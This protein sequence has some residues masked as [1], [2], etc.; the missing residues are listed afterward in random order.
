MAAVRPFAKL[1]IRLRLAGTSAL[2]TLFILCVFAVAIGTLT[3]RRI[4]SDFYHQ[5]SADATEVG[6]RLQA[7]YDP[8]SRGVA[9][10]PKLDLFG[11]PEH[12]LMRVVLADGTVV[13]QTGKAPNFGAPLSSSI[14]IEGYR[15][16]TRQLRSNIGDIFL[17][18]ARPVS[19][20]GSTIA[21][22]QLFLIV[23]VL[24][25]TGLALAAGTMIAARAMAPIAELTAAARE[26]ERTRDP[27]RSV[28]PSQSEDEV[29][30]LGRTLEN[31]LQ[32]LTDARAETET[33]L[34]RQRAFVADASHELRTPLTSVLANLELL[35]ESL[36]GEERDA[37]RSALRSSQRMRRLVEDLLLL[38]RADLGS[39]RARAHAQLDLADVVIEAAGEL[40]PA[41]GAHVLTLD[42]EPT[43]IVG[44]RDDLHR[45]AIN[46]I[47]NALRHTP[48][49]THI[50]V[51]THTDA[52]GCACLVV[53]DGGPGIPDELR[54]R[55]FERFVRG[56]GDRGGSFGLGLAIVQAVSAAHDGSVSV[57][58][59][60]SGGARFVV[61]P[62]PQE[63]PNE[64]AGTPAMPVP[65]GRLEGAREE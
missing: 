16:E 44:A 36:R 25:G 41:A 34:E 45:V 61:S 47:E 21:R 6:S 55:L 15:V 43:P 1:P 30:E 56:G 52:R 35:E 22:L 46:L 4:R 28:P 14:N 2:L 5:V 19:D 39:T 7:N 18:Y 23:G 10:T 33:A 17:Q 42:A 11:A 8:A 12:T 31:M 49:G 48:P 24:A 13:A 54:P 9:V 27:S 57:E 51:A 58:R 60:A 63:R 32:A 38:A 40:E 65:S 29:A 59:S 50:R 26:I 3:S 62:H 37:A 20:L 64:R 53:E